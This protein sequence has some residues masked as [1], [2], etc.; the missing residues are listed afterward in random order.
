MKKLSREIQLKMKANKARDRIDK[1]LDKGSFLEFHMF[2]KSRIVK[3]K[4]LIT[5]A[6][7]TGA[8]TIGG[9]KVFVY[10]QNFAEMG[11]SLGEM[12]AKKIA[13][14]FDMALK[15]GTCIISILDSGGARI[16]EGIYS[17]D[18]YGEIFKRNVEASG[19]ILQL[20]IIVGACAGGAAYSPALTDFIFMIKDQSLMFVTGPKII[21][22]VTGEKVT[23]EELGGA[24]THNEKSGVAHFAVANE[25]GCFSLVKQLF[26]YLPSNNLDDP[27]LY[28]SDDP[29]TRSCRKL[30]DI[31]P[32]DPQKVYDVKE[33]IDLI[34]DRKSFLG[35][36]RYF[37]KNAIIGFAR[38]G[39]RTVGVVANQPKV[40]AGCLDINASNKIAR[41]VR[42]CDAF[43]IP[44]IN[45]V[46][47]PGYLPGKDTEHS[48]IIRHGAKLLYAYSEAQV[49]KI[50]VI[51]RKAY[52]G[53]YI[54]MASKALGYDSVI[55]WPTA[56]IAVMGAE[57]AVELLNAKK[58]NELSKEEIDQ[59]IRDYK[60]K[61]LDVLKTAETDKIDLLIEKKDT[62]E[63]LYRVLEALRTKAY[64]QT[65]K[66]HGNIPL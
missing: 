29:T 44:L 9:R 34:F 41:F 22:T 30:E 11:G 45:L 4:K 50:A 46:D 3:S 47:V 42:F 31:V 33:V 60:K 65:G 32:D 51:L 6:V 17:L 61:Y 59:K 7:V 19:K 20:S 25:D 63:A 12:H 49:P 40:K 36:Q 53:A 28:L 26:S 23:L 21:K 48:G 15:S 37:A 5:D 2:A 57:Q 38:L 56:Q 55:A 16:Q 10:S 58:I 14:V 24:L 39:A 66:R 13:H 43:N 1:L 52:G 27:P 64:K 8:G 18:G 35:L 62:R 54:A